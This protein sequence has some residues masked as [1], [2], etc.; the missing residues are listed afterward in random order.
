M[1]PKIYEFEAGKNPRD[2]LHSTNENDVELDVIRFELTPAVE[3][4]IEAAQQ[5]LSSLNDGIAS[6][7]FGYAKD[8]HLVVNGTHVE[9]S[10]IDGPVPLTSQLLRI[11]D[12][13]IEL[14]LR[15]QGSDTL[16][17]LELNDSLLLNHANDSSLE[18]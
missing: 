3:R 11:E 2:L 15:V 17:T 13:Y 16:F 6:W 10:Y 8:L 4:R 5:H 1:N 7:D 12:Q 9:S 14:V 18:P